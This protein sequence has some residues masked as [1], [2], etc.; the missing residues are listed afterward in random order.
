MLKIN[1]SII[2]YFDRYLLDSVHEWSP[3]A[4]LLSRAAAHGENQYIR[5]RYRNHH[6][7][8]IS[9][10]WNRRLNIS[11]RT[12]YAHF[13]SL[14]IIRF[15]KWKHV[16]S[17]L[18]AVI[19]LSRDS[20]SSYGLKSHLL[21]TGAV[22][23]RYNGDIL[24]AFRNNWFY[25][26]RFRYVARRFFVNI[27]VFVLP[28]VLFQIGFATHSTVKAMQISPLKKVHTKWNVHIARLA[29]INRLMWQKRCAQIPN[30][31]MLFRT[32]ASK[33]LTTFLV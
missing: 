22:H 4:F 16:D 23:S 19:Q 14:H 29:L 2:L 26:W 18:Q 9:P 10:Q 13:R 1:I 5:F 7:N 17:C 3:L 21:L 32:N 31:L 15:N 20:G 11:Y 12:K 27:K 6:I 30:E 28:H 33:E 25:K 24:S 8:R